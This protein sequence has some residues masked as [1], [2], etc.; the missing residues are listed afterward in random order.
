MTNLVMTS[1]VQQVQPQVCKV[2][3]GLVKL[4]NP[5]SHLTGELWGMA[6]VAEVFR[7]ERDTDKG[8][9]TSCASRYGRG[10]LR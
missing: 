8:E 9:V 10:Q 5:G 1:C 3:L 7:L 4:L 6:Q 2:Q